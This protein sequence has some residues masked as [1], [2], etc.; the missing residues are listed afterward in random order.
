MEYYF[1]LLWVQLFPM[2]LHHELRAC[3]ACYHVTMTKWWW[4]GWQWR[5][6]EDNGVAAE[7]VMLTP[8]QRQR[9][10]RT[11]MQHC[12]VEEACLAT[13]S[14]IM[15]P[16][17]RPCFSLCNELLVMHS[18]HVIVGAPLTSKMRYYN[19]TQCLACMVCSRHAI[20]NDGDDVCYQFIWNSFVVAKTSRFQVVSCMVC[21]SLSL[22]E[23]WL[24]TCT[25][26]ID[27]DL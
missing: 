24:S 8:I 17:S 9:K 20:S 23:H 27:M 6:H 14:G 15:P 7:C 1:W 2:A 5:S 25:V 21:G 13:D 26:V 4:M 18:L 19:S 12:S 16:M 11:H 22:G 3:T 10:K